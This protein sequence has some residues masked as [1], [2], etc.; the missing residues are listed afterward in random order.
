M[1]SIRRLI[2][3]RSLR[4]SLAALVYAFSPAV[5]VAG[6]SAVGEFVAAVAL[7]RASA[8]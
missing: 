8:S 2:G 7:V 1:T 4:G 5:A 6:G 3:C